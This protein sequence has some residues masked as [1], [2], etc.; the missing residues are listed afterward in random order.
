[1]LGEIAV[2][3]SLD[4]FRYV[5][6]EHKSATRGDEVDVGLCGVEHPLYTVG[7]EAIILME[8]LDP[9]PFRES[10][11]SIPVRNESEV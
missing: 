3:P 4:L 6:R 1:M 8:K 10:D 7:F 9:L 5:G 11:G 2:V